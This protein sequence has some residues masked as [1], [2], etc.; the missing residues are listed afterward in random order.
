MPPFNALF[1]PLLGGF[2][3]VSLWYPTR[4]FTLRS[5]GY[6]LIFAASIAGTCFLFLSCLLNSCCKPFFWYTHLYNLWRWVVPLENTGRAAFA[7]LIGASI[8]WPLNKLGNHVR[9]LSDQLAVDRVIRHK[10]DPLE[11]LLRECL[12]WEM[13]SITLKSGKV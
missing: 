5:D 7:F 3:C 9:V 4:Y 2:I 11:T 1:L 6:R 8:W 13:I 12:G 10:K